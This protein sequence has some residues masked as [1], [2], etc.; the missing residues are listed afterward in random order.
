[1]AEV[2]CDVA[3]AGTNME[4]AFVL[5]WRTRRMRD[6]IISVHCGQSLDYEILSLR[7]PKSAIKIQR[8]D[9]W[10]S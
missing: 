3:N 8:R 2:E 4:A 6:V 9:G 1:M 10:Y 5:T 7:Y